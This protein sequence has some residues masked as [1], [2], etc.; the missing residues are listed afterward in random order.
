MVED[1][2]AARRAQL[3]LG[4]LVEISVESPASA[5]V[6]AGVAAAFAVIARVHRALSLHDRESELSRVNRNAPA[7]VQTLSA[8]LRAVLSCSLELAARS[9]GAFDPTVGGRVAALGFLPPQARSARDASWRDVELT[10]RGVR[11]ARPLVLDFGGIAKG[12]AVDCAIDA[13]RLHFIAAGRVN[14][15]GDLRVFGNQSE[16]VHVR[17]GGPQGIILPLVAITDGA[18]ATSAFGGQRRR[19]GGRWA[20]PLIDPRD[21]LPRM[22]TRTVSVVASTC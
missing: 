1:R 11:F 16:L 5:P 15:G 14:A 8:D 3:W 12:Y 21:R 17:T 20:T 9:G 4:T 22:S 2:Y 10:P 7:A 18:V 6:E 19:I 13:L